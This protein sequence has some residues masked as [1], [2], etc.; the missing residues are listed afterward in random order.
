MSEKQKL[1]AQQN[2]LF[3]RTLGMGPIPGSATMT[4]GIAALEESQRS[5]IV[6]SVM[7]FDAFTEDND[8][9]GEHDFGSIDH[10]DAGRVFWKIDYYD[11]SLQY[12]SEDPSDL[13]QTHRVLTIML[14]SEY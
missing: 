2:D 9:Y 10:E 1:I 5:T 4:A 12:G 14:A 6:Q 8:P 11:T 13:T 7:A 3:R